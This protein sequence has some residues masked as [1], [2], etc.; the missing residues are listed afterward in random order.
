M[1][2]ST[3]AERIL[4]D[5]AGNGGHAVAIS[6]GIPDWELGRITL[7]VA[8]DGAVVVEQRGSVGDND[9]TARWTSEETAAFAALLREE[10]LLG[11]APVPGDRQPD[12]APV[13]LIV[14]D[15]AEAV[16]SASVWEADR[17]RDAH[18]DRVLKTFDSTV[19]AVSGGKLP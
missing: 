10:A 8:G 1:S 15:G 18:L 16:H 19:R 7:R 14:F 9:Y 13:D 11:I 3:H 17:E 5:F 2:E 12:D 6:V 4:E